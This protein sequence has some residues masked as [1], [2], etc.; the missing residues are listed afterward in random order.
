MVFIQFLFRK[1]NIYFSFYHSLEK[2]KRLVVERK[3]QA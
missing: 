1:A 3:K 2:A